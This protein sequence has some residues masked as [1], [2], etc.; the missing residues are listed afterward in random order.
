MKKLRFIAALGALAILSSCAFFNDKTVE[1]AFNSNPPG[2]SIF[3][4]GVNYGQTPATLN[5]EPKQYRVNLVKE[6]YGSATIS[7]DIW[8]GTIRTDVDG[9]RTSDGTRCFLDM[10]SL[11]F[12]FN[13]YNAKRC[14]DFKQKQYFAT[15]PYTG[16]NAGMAGGGSMMNLGNNPRD[17]VDY[18]YGQ[19]GAQSYGQGYP[20]GG[21]NG[22]QGQFNQGQRSRQ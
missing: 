5:I 10:M 14:G 3:I 21:M 4:D 11:V 6:G 8:W 7:T 19:G 22:Q 16:Q 2:A 13:A 18:Y 15:I 1:V 17:V 9:N 12:S 20:Q